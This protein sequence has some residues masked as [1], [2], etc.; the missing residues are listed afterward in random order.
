M[1]IAKVHHKEVAEDFV[2]DSFLSAHQSYKNFK[3]K[4]NVKTWLYSILKHN[5]ADYYRLKYKQNTQAAF[6]VFDNFFYENDRWI[7]EYVIICG[8]RE[9]A[10]KGVSDKFPSVITRSCDLSVE[11]KEKNFLNGFQKIIVT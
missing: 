5:I 4:S 1:P 3:S 7:P 11:K 8:R 6:D 9:S 2:Q 10:L